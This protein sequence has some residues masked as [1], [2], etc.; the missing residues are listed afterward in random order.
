MVHIRRAI[1]IGDILSS[2]HSLL[3]AFRMSVGSECLD[4]SCL[5]SD[6][7]IS[8]YL[9]GVTEQKSTSD[10]LYAYVRHVALKT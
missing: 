6:A 9:L 5:R 4:K 3:L 7:R 10:E 2:M 1:P 8:G